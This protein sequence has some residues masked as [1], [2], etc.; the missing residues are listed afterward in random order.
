M[1]FRVCAFSAL[2]SCLGFG[3]WDLGFRVLAL[4]FLTLATAV[5]ADDLPRN[6]KA[7]REGYPNVDVIYYS[8][9]MPDGTLIR[10]GGRV[11]KSASG[12]D[13]TRLFLGSEGTLGVITE[14]QLRLHG[15][16]EAV[17]SATCQFNT[18]RDAVD[19]GLA[20]RDRQSRRAARDER[21]R[22]WRL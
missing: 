6:S 21:R 3:A 20:R 19:V 14:I 17:S 4:V 2:K 7:P 22:G 5:R 9:A 1:I 8:V 11:R 10:T 12:Y 16:P 15:I 13:L 18:L